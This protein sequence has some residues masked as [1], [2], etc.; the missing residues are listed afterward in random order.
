M[1]QDQ[2]EIHP[3]DVLKIKFSAQPSFFKVIKADPKK[4]KLEVM[5]LLDNYDKPFQEGSI[6]NIGPSI[7]NQYWAYTKCPTEEAKEI[8]TLFQNNELIKTLLY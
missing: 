1:S 7:Y 5:V 6:I 8:E 2:S 4:I 3:G